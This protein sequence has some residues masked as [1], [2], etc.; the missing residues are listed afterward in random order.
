MKDVVSRKYHLE[1]GFWHVKPLVRMDEKT[2]LKTWMIMETLVGATGFAITL[3][4]SL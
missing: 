2:T 1:Y 4:I 3:I